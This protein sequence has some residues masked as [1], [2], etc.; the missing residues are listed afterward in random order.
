[1]VEDIKKE[2]NHVTEILSMSDLVQLGSIAA[3]E[4]CGG[5]LINFRYIYD[6]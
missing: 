1:M 4:Y 6:N 5:P 2:G 3:V